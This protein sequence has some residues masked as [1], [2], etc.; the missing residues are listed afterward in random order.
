LRLGTS[1]VETYRAR[2]KTKL[3]LENTAQLTHEAVR[4]VQTLQSVA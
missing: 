4:W 3:L 1:T 2:I